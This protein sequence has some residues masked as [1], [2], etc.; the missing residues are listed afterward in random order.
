MDKN[1]KFLRMVNEGKHY[2]EIANEFLVTKRTIQNWAKKN[3]VKVK[4]KSNR[5]IFFKF[6][7]FDKID[8][9]EKAYILGFIAADGYIDTRNRSLNITLSNKD[10]CMLETIAEALDFTGNIREELR[11]RITISFCSKAMVKDL[12]KYGV[13]QNKTSTVFIPDIP[14]ELIRHFLRGY[15]DGDGYVGERQAVL[16]TTSKAFERDLIDY[17]DKNNLGTPGVAK[18]SKSSNRF[19]FYRKDAKFLK[20]IYE[21]STIYMPRKKESYNK[22]WQPYWKQKEVHDKELVR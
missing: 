9:E 7:Y 15:F 6:D 20:H 1:D 16:V 8:S 21:N 13:V 5:K 12:S 17:I 3:D 4:R 10:R 2:D 19:V 18:A 11:N 14:E 22:N